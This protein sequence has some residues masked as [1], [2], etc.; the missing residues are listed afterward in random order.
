MLLGLSVHACAT[1]C[2]KCEESVR[3]MLKEFRRYER[4]FEP[5]RMQGYGRFSRRPGAIF[6]SLGSAALS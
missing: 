5:H 1:K 2:E 4:G 6:A 3:T